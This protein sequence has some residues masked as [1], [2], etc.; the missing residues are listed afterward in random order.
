MTSPLMGEFLG[1]AVLI[2]FG[3]G[4]VASCLLK[5]S[6]AEGAGWVA[7]TAGWAFAVIMGVF[8]ANAL[9]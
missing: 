2:V 4:V 1:T 9:G 8:T 5:E 3:N 6:K 7:I